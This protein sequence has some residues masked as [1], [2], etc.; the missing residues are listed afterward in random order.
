M[1]GACKGGTQKYQQARDR[2]MGLLKTYLQTRQ[3]IGA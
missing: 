1:W 2:Y 3:T